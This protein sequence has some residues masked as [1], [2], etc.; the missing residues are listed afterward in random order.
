MK[1]FKLIIVIGLLIL[2]LQYACTTDK[3]NEPMPDVDCVN[4]DATYDGAVKAIV[5][6]SCAHSGC[7]LTGGDGPGDFRTYDGMSTYFND[8]GIRESVIGL[9]NDPENG[10]PPNW[11]TNDGPTDLTDEEFK[12]MQC[13]INSG[14]PEN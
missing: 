8:N 5:D 10:M 4:Y 7:H 1:Y 6:N 14:Y 9:R 2:G 11:I 3:L 12:I 13:W